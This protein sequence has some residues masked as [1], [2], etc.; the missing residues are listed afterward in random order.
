M[1]RIPPL[2]LPPP[3]CFQVIHWFGV[4]FNSAFFL[5]PWP[6]LVIILKGI[7]MSLHLALAR[8]LIQFQRIVNFC[9]TF[10]SPATTLK[11]ETLKIENIISKREN[12]AN[13]Y[14]FP[15]ALQ[16]HGLPSR[17]D[18]QIFTVRFVRTLHFLVHL[19]PYIKERSWC[20]AALCHLTKRQFPEN[21][22]AKWL[23]YRIAN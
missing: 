7:L 10:G 20:Q 15:S 21:Q 17:R 4:Y 2:P 11:T 1:G 14:M 19:F 16:M 9:S 5:F 3:Y 13:N 8:S 22:F 23:I 6:V 12:A 18:V